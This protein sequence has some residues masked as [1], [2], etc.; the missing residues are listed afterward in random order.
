MT[1]QE[2]TSHRAELVISY[3]PGEVQV[4]SPG[5]VRANHL[6]SA[7]WK[8]VAQKVV[9]DFGMDAMVDRAAALTYYTVLSAAPTVLALYSIA[10]L[11]LPRDA[12][13]VDALLGEFVVRY[14]PRDLEDEAA[15]FLQSVVGEP[16][17][18]TLALVVSILLSLLTASAYARSFSRSANVIYGRA[19]GRNIFLIWVTMWLLTLVLVVGAVGL[20]FAS[21]MQEHL[22]I[23][24]LTPLARPL[25]LT[26]VVEFLT[27]AFFPVWRWVRVPVMVIVAVLLVACLYYFAPNVRPGR[28]RLLTVGSAAAL[29]VAATVWTGFSAYLSVVG[30]RSAYGAFGTA[31]VVVVVAWAVNLGLLVGVKIDAEVL[32]VKELQCGYDSVRRIQA[33]PRSM[34]AV[35]FRLKVQ[36]WMDRTA[37]QVQEENA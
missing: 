19:E 32:R 17:H 4:S 20:I 27:Q 2:P 16:R 18:N 30:I 25:G 11:L 8:L 12:A 37:R 14:V 22:V 28:F 1:E 23:G 5:H 24:L 34:G 33:R 29:V 35:R 21:L 6:H 10:T 7:G 15:Q 36:R 13:A 3:G 31:L 9:F 26:G